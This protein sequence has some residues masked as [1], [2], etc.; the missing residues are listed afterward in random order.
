MPCSLTALKSIFSGTQKTT[1][2]WRHGIIFKRKTHVCGMLAFSCESN[3]IPCSLSHLNLCVMASKFRLRC[4]FQAKCQI[5]GD[6]FALSCKR[7]RYGGREVAGSWFVA[8]RPLHAQ[9]IVRPLHLAGSKASKATWG[10][11]LFFL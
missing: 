3:A 11:S 4:K 2:N 5:C 10:K 7:P 9:Q 6:A 1:D 8:A